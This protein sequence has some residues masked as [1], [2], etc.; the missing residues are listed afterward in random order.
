[1]A[2]L[3]AAEEV[4]L[5]DCPFGLFMWHETLALKTLYRARDGG[6]VAY[7]VSSGEY[8]YGDARLCDELAKLMVRPVIVADEEAVSEDHLWL[9][10]SSRL[11]QLSGDGSGP[12]RKG[13]RA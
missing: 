9:S 4:S 1:M 6:I 7:T 11:S 12:A 10:L 3:Y 13:Q 2:L 5:A 8:F